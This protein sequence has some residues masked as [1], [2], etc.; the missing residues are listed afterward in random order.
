[1]AHLL[2]PQPCQPGSKASGSKTPQQQT[3]N[4]GEALVADHLVAQG[5]R[6][7]ARQW[8]CRW[9]ELDVVAHKGSTLAFVEV[10]TWAR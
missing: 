8:R 3:G 9:G 1:M 6:I 5:W 2:D 7:L 4:R 10:K